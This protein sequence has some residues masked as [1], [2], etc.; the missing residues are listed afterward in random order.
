MLTT[1]S[2]AGRSTSSRP[3]PPAATTAPRVPAL[4]MR[5]RRRDQS[6][7]GRP[8]PVVAARRPGHPGDPG[9]GTP[10]E[11]TLPGH[12][13]GT[14]AEGTPEEASPVGDATRCIDAPTG[15]TEEG[16]PRPASA[17]R[18]RS[19]ISPT[20]TASAA[21]TSPSGRDTSGWRTAAIAA[22]SPKQTKTATPIE[23]RRA[24]RSPATAAI[25]TAAPTIRTLRASLSLVPKSPTI[26]S[27]AP[28]GWKLM[29]SVPMAM[30][31]E[32]ASRTIP[33]N[34]SATAI[35]APAASAPDSAAA[36]QGPAA[37]AVPASRATSP[38]TDTGGR[39][40]SAGTLRRVTRA[41]YHRTGNRPL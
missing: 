35:A 25:A 20:A 34:S 15:I 3:T 40:G 22:R 17:S 2:T 8:A 9:E 37:R 24:A 30:T 29:T 33:A 13:A 32:G 1:P 23:K 21:F 14:P 10:A 4:A 19:T 18:A 28:G 31:S 6:G 36:H 7:V 27:L 16:K 26:R 12:P 11:G 39:S 5:N 38:G 41:P